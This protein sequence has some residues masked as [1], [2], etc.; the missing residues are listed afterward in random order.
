MTN[1]DRIR[2]TP[3]EKIVDFIMETD[4]FIEKRCDSLA[5]PLPED[6]LDVSDCRECVRK[7]LREEV[8]DPSP[9]AQ[10]DKG[11]C[12]APGWKTKEAEI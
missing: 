3:E 4:L 2:Q 10:D 9:P 7:W 8:K 6:A 11:G 12:G 1:L 5:C